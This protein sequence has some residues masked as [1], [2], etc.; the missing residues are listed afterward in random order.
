MAKKQRNIIETVEFN[1]YAEA[2]DMVKTAQRKRTRVLIGLGIAAVA[3][4]L[5]ILGLSNG[6]NNPTYFFGACLLAFPAYLIGGGLGGALKTAWRLGTI[7]WILIPFPYDIL[8]GL[9]T[10]LFSLFAFFCFPVVF[11]FTNY[12][13]HNRNY[14]EAKKYLSY[15]QRS[16]VSA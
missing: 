11:V 16:R 4:L 15:Y 14:K 8:T 5:T 3:S 2:Q 6:G 12:V 1:N 9:L 10:F 7:G 13:A